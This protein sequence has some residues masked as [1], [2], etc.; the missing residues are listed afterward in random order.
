[1][2]GISNE[3]IWEIGEIYVRAPMAEKRSTCN[4]HGTCNL[5]GRADI[6]VKA[7]LDTKLTVE[8]RPKPHPRH[9]DI[10][11]WPAS[12]EKQQMLATELANKS[13]FHPPPV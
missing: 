1:M 8:P 12:M 6:E 13:N 11:S 10:M 5:Y 9:A 3:E 2:T 7:I 4:L